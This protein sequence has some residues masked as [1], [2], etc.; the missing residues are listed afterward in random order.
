MSHDRPRVSMET[1]DV[2]VTVTGRADVTPAALDRLPPA[3]TGL[4][5]RADL[6]GDLD[7]ESLRRHFSGQ[8]VYALRSVRYGGRCADRDG[9][10]RFRLLAAARGYDAVDLEADRDLAPELL[11]RIP[12]HQRRVWWSGDA[13]DLG[14]LRARFSRAARTPARLYVLACQPRPDSFTAAAVPVRLLT[15]LKRRDVTAFATGP[16]AAWTRI[17][18]PWL[19]AP[20]VFETRAAVGPLV[21]D[22]P[23]PDLPPVD[24]LYGIVGRALNTPWF[25]SAV[26]AAFRAL[27]MPCLFLPFTVP[28]AESFRTLFW[29]GFSGGDLGLPLGGLTVAA[30]YKEVAVAVA[31]TADAHAQ[32]AGAANL[33]LRRDGWL[34]TT[35]DGTAAAAALAA[36]GPLRGRTAAVVGCGAAGRAAAAALSSAGARVTLVNRGTGRGQRA[37]TSLGL[38]FVPLRDFT[39]SR[40]GIVVHATPLAD[41]VPFSVDRLR[42]GTTVAD[43][44][45]S[46]EPTALATAARGRGLAVIDG[47]TILEHEIAQQFQLMTGRPIPPVGNH[48]GR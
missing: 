19:G 4:E 11:T 14:S 18:A 22:Y 44:V 31:G 5:V 28:D 16:A 12:G 45:C 13:T 30:P 48:Q 38:A 6:V 3:V 2:V 24:R 26:N 33:L 15:V 35:T 37:A 21:R 47:R 27:A 9:D 36:A 10:R 41:D 17:L 20:V 39:P 7:P 25:L 34:A 42:A 32:R 23:F 29:P 43:F 40:Y 1:A 8:L 46:A